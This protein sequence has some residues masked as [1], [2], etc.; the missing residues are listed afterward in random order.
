M[1][2]GQHGPIIQ[3]VIVYLVA[4]GIGWPH[5][6][7]T[8]GSRRGCMKSVIMLCLTPFPFSKFDSRMPIN[9]NGA[10]CISNSSNGTAWMYSSLDVLMKNPSVMARVWI[11]KVC[12]FSFKVSVLPFR[13]SCFRCR[14]NSSATCSNCSTEIC[15]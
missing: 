14:A 7:G 4:S 1:A 10:L 15:Q 5:V 6:N 3:L 8:D 12:D 2:I 13:D 9:R 11:S